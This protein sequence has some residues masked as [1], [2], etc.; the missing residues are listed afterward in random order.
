MKEREKTKTDISHPWLLPTVWSQLLR[1]LICYWPKP[2]EHSQTMFRDLFRCGIFCKRFQKCPF[3]RTW[4]HW[5]D[6]QCS[7]FGRLIPTQF[8]LDSTHLWMNFFEIGLKYILFSNFFFN[9]GIAN[10][11]HSINKN[12][13]KGLLFTIIFMSKM[14]IARLKILQGGFKDIA[15]VNH[16]FHSTNFYLKLVNWSHQSYFFYSIMT[17]YES[18]WR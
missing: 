2:C 16:L 12:A 8:L 6:F 5:L 15:G 11:L 7:S 10:I 9:S 3:Q 13:I 18:F 17:F 1:Q 4:C 14:W